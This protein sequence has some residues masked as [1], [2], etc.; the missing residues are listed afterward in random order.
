MLVKF[1]RKNEEKSSLTC[2]LGKAWYNLVFDSLDAKQMPQPLI[3]QGLQH[4]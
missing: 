1:Y 2:Q 3:I 4:F